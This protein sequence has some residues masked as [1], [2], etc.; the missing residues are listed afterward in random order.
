MHPVCVLDGPENYGKHKLMG[1]LGCFY[2]RKLRDAD[3]SAQRSPS[4]G[5]NEKVVI[6]QDLWGRLR[7]MVM[8]DLMQKAATLMYNLVK[9][10][11]HFIAVQD[12]ACNEHRVEAGN[13]KGDALFNL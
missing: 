3:G 1:Q 2:A 13:A 12:V 11:P 9:P 10:G 5:R 7:C 8:L 6:A 4:P